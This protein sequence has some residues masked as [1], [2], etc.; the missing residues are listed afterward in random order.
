MR[1]ASYENAEEAEFLTK[2]YP[3][4]TG[5]LN[6]TTFA[7]LAP[8]GKE[9]LARSGRGPA[10]P[11]D[12]PHQPDVPAAPEH[13]QEFATLLKEKMAGF[14]PKGELSALP[15]SLDFR[16]AL[17]I[18]ACDDQPLVVAFAKDHKDRLELEMRLARL[19]WNEAFL[20][21][22]QYAIVDD[23]EDMQAIPALPEGDFLAIVQADLFG[24]EGVVLGA[25]PASADEPSLQ[26][27]LRRGLAAHARQTYS[28]REHTARGRREGVAWETEIPITDEH[29]L[30]EGGEPRPRRRD[31]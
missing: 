8:D 13:T 5:L 9:L 15:Q 12:A 28:S 2:V 26:D 7:L 20:G 22:L 31:R 6:N 25:V 17:N 18:A 27:M 4:R 23:R 14:Q 30:R 16:R 19:A 3:G 1:L 24:L 10:F 21:R 29:A 11:I